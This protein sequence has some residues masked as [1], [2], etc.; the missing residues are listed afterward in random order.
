M[1]ITS[2]SDAMNT[3]VGTV[4]GQCFS[5]VPS[6]SLIIFQSNYTVKVKC[7]NPCTPQFPP[8]K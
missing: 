1:V 3:T 6:S 2:W 5:N 7:I 8:P 4:G